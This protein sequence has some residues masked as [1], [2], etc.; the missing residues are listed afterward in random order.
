[1]S[2]SVNQIDQSSVLSS[3]N[4]CRELLSEQ[5]WIL[6]W[7][8]LKTLRPDLKQEDFLKRKNQLQRDGYHL[9]GLF[10]NA[11]VVC[12]ASYT[13][14]PHAALDREMM[15]HD[16]STL[17]GEDLRG[18]GSELLSYLDVLAVELNCRRTFLASTKA[19]EFYI[20]NG[21]IAHARALKKLHENR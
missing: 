12:V 16:M 13:I 6:G 11:K 14:S 5:D 1:M 17:A 7:H 10:K 9:V 20:K 18:Y 15:I 3:E 21:Y 19:S 2:T 8:A 4:F